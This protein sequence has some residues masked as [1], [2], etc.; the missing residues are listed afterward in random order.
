MALVNV[1]FSLGSNLGD[2]EKNIT[3]ALGRMDEAFGR[4]YEALSKFIET[5]PMGF[6]GGKFLNAAALYRIR[7]MD[8]AE[9]TGAEKVLDI[10]KAIEWSMG[11]TDQPQYD[12]AGERI[13]HSRVIDI[14]ILFYG[15]ETI[16]TPRLT[17]P[18]KG[19]SDRP[20]VM[21]PLLEIARPS[22]K[23]AFPEYFK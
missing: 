20:F 1:Y 4:H 11:R 9:G 14:D 19:I 13:Y 22:L 23:K 18:H 12:A 8:G 16:D 10:V 17:I 21:I 3:E 2:R 7:T 15:K 5:E 6:S